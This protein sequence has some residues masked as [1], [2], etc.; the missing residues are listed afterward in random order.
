VKNKPVTKDNINIYYS[1][2]IKTKLEIAGV[3]G[4]FGETD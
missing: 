3:G 4:L 1:L 2:V